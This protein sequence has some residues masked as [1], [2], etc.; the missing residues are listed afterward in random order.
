MSS[1]LS[2]TVIFFAVTAVLAVGQVGTSVLTG[3]ITD[4]TGSSIPTARIKVVNE[5]S[6]AEQSTLTNQA[7]AFRVGSLVPGPYRIEV[8]ADGFQKLLRGPVILEVAQTIALD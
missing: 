6:G 8:E 4:P 7:G 2:R 3:R 5:Q 1:L